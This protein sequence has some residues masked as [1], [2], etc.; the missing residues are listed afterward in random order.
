MPRGRAPRRAGQAR[1]PP[2]GPR[3]ETLRG[4]NGY[5]KI[6]RHGR[7]EVA[8]PA[9]RGV[10]LTETYQIRF[11]RLHGVCAGSAVRMNVDE[12][13]RKDA[14]SWVHDFGA[15]RRAPTFTTTPFSTSTTPS[16]I[17]SNGV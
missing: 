9:V 6:S 7:C 17:S 14:I 13:R 10:K 2:R 1:R 11:A 5:W 3:A 16:P 4:S 8:R 12:A 15:S